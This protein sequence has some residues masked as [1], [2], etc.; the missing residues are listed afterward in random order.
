MAVS[1]SYSSHELIKQYLLLY[2]KIIGKRNNL[3]LCLSFQ[4]MNIKCADDTQE[5]KEGQENY[6]LL[7]CFDKSKKI[8]NCTKDEK[9][10]KDQ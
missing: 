4:C 2:N 3:L 9:R 1:L 10:D 7:C 8:I 5:V 6:S